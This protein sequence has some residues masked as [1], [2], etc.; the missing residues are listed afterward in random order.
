MDIDREREPAYIYTIILGG[1]FAGS[2][3]GRKKAT[4]ESVACPFKADEICALKRTPRI[5]PARIPHGGRQTVYTVGRK[6][7]FWMAS[8]CIHERY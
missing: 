5:L 3:E 7:L 4:V 2:G 8:P 6:Q 1:A